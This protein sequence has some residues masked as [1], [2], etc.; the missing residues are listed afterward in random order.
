[1]PDCTAPVLGCDAAFDPVI[2]AVSRRWPA[3]TPRER[4]IIHHLAQGRS[5]AE[6]SCHLYLSKS[7][8]KFHVTN[9]LRKTGAR[10]T[11]QLLAMVIEALAGG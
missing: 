2:Q 11:R 7:A 4:E 5:T 8:V 1:M 6:I 10:S 3:L 9:L